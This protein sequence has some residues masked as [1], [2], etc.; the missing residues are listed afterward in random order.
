M[1]ILI[2]RRDK[3]GFT[4]IEIIAA[5][6]MFSVIIGALCSV[7]FVTLRIRERN[8]E[9][10]EK[11]LPHQYIMEIVKRDIS[12][13]VPPIGILAGPFIGEKIEEGSLRLDQIELH[14]ASGKVTSESP[15]GDIQHVAYYLAQS[16]DSDSYNLIRAIKRNLLEM[17]VEEPEEQILLS[18]VESFKLEYFDGEM[19][20]DDWDSTV[21]ENELPR[22]V[23]IEIT[24]TS[25]DK[26]PIEAIVLI[27]AS[28]VSKDGRK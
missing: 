5:T 3:K 4:L 13:A 20:Q 10:V 16:E 2:F 1:R 15:W 8:F 28:V 11:S 9:R 27:S 23:G 19:W 22:A 7:F 17:V 6:A 26:H 24:F 25:T 21:V 18:D 14:T 12:S